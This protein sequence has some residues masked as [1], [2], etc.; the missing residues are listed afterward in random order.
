M[1]IKLISYKVFKKLA[2]AKGEFPTWLEAQKAL[3]EDKIKQ[4]KSCLSQTNDN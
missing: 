3:L 4:G 1:S 2:Y